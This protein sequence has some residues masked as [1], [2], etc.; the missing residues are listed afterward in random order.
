M[1]TATGG[2]YVTLTSQVVVYTPAERADP[3]PLLR[4]SPSLWSQPRLANVQT[5]LSGLGRL[6]PSL[7]L[8]SLAVMSM[9]Y[10]FRFTGSGSNPNTPLSLIASLVQVRFQQRESKRSLGQGHLCT[11]NFQGWWGVKQLCSNIHNNTPTPTSP[12]PLSLANYLL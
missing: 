5:G 7:C 10:H 1:D 9:I 2:L 11:S 8:I 4:L 3:L 6:G 12:A